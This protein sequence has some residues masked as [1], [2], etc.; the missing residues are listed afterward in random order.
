MY[1]LIAA[2]AA[3]FLF[4]NC[5]PQLQNLTQTKSPQPQ[6]QPATAGTSTAP[7]QFANEIAAAKAPFTN[8]KVQITKIAGQSLEEVRSKAGSVSLPVGQRLIVIL[9]NECARTQP[10]PISQLAFNPE[11]EFAEL[12]TQTYSLILQRQ[13]SIEEIQRMAELDQ[14]V[15]G[16]TQDEL[17]KASKVNDPQVSKQL[18]YLS[19]GGIDAENFFSDKVLGSTSPIVVAVIDSG[20]NY[21]HEDLKNH[22]WKNP[23]NGAIGYNFRN[24]N[25]NT[26]DDF[27]HGTFVAGL[28]AAQTNN[29]VGLAGVMGHDIKILPLKIQDSVGNAY[30][31]DMNISID[32]SR[33]KAVDVINI[34][35]EGSGDQPALRSALNAA[36]NA[37]IFIAA[38]AGNSGD[39]LG[40]DN[41]VVPAHYGTSLAGMMTVGS[42]DAYSGARSGFSNFSTTYV[43]IAAPGSGGVYSTHKDGGYSS[44]QGTSF[45]AP[46]I[47]ALTISFFKKHAIAYSAATVENTLAAAAVSRQPL[48]NDFAAGRTLDLRA[49][50]E[51]L[52]R[53]YLNSIEG[54]YDEN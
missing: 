15:I 32:Y 37:N 10:G 52:K 48:M 8:Q 25:T 26:F 46:L 19:I 54:G 51:Y 5:Q 17:I 45:S 7:E 23:I 30:I 9:N 12:E 13:I 20:I 42:V 11:N 29:Q 3:L 16:L 39:E 49:L 6:R 31:S 24:N 22:I 35:M 1:A 4:Q 28:I 27:G 34:S 53:S 43:E 41:I 18:H 38:A 2:L 21:S 44:N 36:I 47:A 33:S 40:P 14:C 50:A